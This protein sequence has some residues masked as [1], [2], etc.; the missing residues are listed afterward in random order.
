MQ[1]IL[2]TCA[3]PTLLSL[4]RER[5][6]VPSKSLKYMDRQK[7][8]SIRS[9]MMNRVNLC[10]LPKVS[11]FFFPIYFRRIRSTKAGRTRSTHIVLAFFLLK[12]S[13]QI[14]H[15]SPQE[16]CTNINLFKSSG[17]LYWQKH[18]YLLNQLEKYLGVSPLQ[19]SLMVN[20]PNISVACAEKYTWFLKNANSKESNKNVLF[21][22]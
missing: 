5:H 22:N 12:D 14:A 1:G 2:A 10:S 20:Y 17:Y 4:S 7:A 19:M 3:R 11:K 8:L 6:Q 21:N 16:R 18:L 15:S 13:S 9:S